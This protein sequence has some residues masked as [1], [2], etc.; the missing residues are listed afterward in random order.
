M[1]KKA[2]HPRSRKAEKLP[3]KTKRKDRIAQ[4]KKLHK[5]SG[6][7]KK[8]LLLT[9]RDKL[10]EKGKIPTD[11]EIESNIIEFL[12]GEELE[13]ESYKTGSVKHLANKKKLESMW[14]DA[15]DGR[16]LIPSFSSSLE[17]EAFRI[18]KGDDGGLSAYNMRVFIIKKREEEEE[19]EEQS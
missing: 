8:R 18:W 13:L 11:I 1:A 12:R 5:L 16:L 3:G 2:L 15:R 19:G 17:V 10:P 6:S 7:L 4:K 9:L 14:I